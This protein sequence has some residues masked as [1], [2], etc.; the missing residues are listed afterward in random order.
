MRRDA[1]VPC[2]VVNAVLKG[3]QLLCFS[4][5]SGYLT[6][7]TGASCWSF[8]L[9]RCQF[10][11]HTLLVF[12][13]TVL[14]VS[15]TFLCSTCRCI[16]HGGL[17][18]LAGGIVLFILALTAGHQPLLGWVSSGATFLLLYTCLLYTS[19]A[20]DEED[21]VDLGGRRIIKKKKI[22]NHRKRDEMKTNVK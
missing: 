6:S 19:D 22:Q 16:A 4:P 15:S 14:G 8:G 2:A 7:V 3:G 17:L 11:I 12:D 18:F 10:P 20:A 5:T 21:S 13:S 1:A 9:F